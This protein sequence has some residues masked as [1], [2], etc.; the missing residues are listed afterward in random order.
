MKSFQEIRERIIRLGRAEYRYDRLVSDFGEHYT[1]LVRAN[2]QPLPDIAAFRCWLR[3][4][5]VELRPGLLDAWRDMAGH[6]GFAL[7]DK[8]TAEGTGIYV[9]RMSCYPL[10]EI[11][12]FAGFAVKKD[13]KRAQS[14]VEVA[15]KEHSSIQ[16]H[17]ESLDE[18]ILRPLFFQG[19]SR[20]A[21]V[22]T[23]LQAETAE[24]LETISGSDGSHYVV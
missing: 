22:Q 11:V 19:S 2:Y 9:V 3:H 18:A 17:S 6:Y 15:V 13:G 24:L 5:V 21:N 14:S 10:E 12:R 16:K 23:F 1:E 7:G 20:L 8:I 4:L